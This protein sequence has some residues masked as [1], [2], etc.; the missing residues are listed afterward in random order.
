[1]TCT[2]ASFHQGLLSMPM[3]TNPPALL[4]VAPAAVLFAAALPP[5]AAAGVGAAAAA[6]LRCTVRP[7][8][9]AQCS[10]PRQSTA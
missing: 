7:L 3:C 10:T 4:P 9:A 1:M 8:P 5:V 6:A 2:A